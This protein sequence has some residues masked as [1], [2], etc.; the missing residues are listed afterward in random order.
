MV[1][2]Y[3]NLLACLLMK[4]SDLLGVNIHLQ[5]IGTSCEICIREQKKEETKISVN[6]TTLFRDQ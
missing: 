6:D 4:Y 1:L 5:G 3:S 2:R